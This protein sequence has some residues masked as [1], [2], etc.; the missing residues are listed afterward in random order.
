[1]KITLVGMGMGTPDT[2]TGEGLQALEQAQVIIGAQRLLE[3]LPK[4]C[5]ALC[6]QA[7]KPA[8]ILSLIEKSKNCDSLCVV[9]SGDTGFYSGSTALLPLLR[10]QG[11][12]PKVICGI[13][14]V[15]YFAAQL[16]RPWQNVRLVSAHGVECDVVGQVLMA[17][18]TFFLTGG[19][20]TIKAMLECL[21]DAGLGELEVWVG[22][23]LSLP[24]QHITH[25]TPRQLRG[26]EFASLS[27]LWVRRQPQKAVHPFQIAGIPDKEFIRG[28][29]PMTK[30]EV[31]AAILAKLCLA[32]GEV[33]W[34]VG[35]GT[36]SVSVELARVSPLTKVFAVETE[37]EALELIA[38]NRAKF[39]AFQIQ[40]VPGMAPAA[41]APLPAP[42]AVFVGGSKGNLHE[43]L[44]SVLDKNARARVVI[45]AIALETLAEAIQSCKALEMQEMEVTQISVSRTRE[46]GRYHMLTGQNPIFLISARGKETE[47]P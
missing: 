40:I 6:Y 26:R 21:E 8:E 10:E 15:Q 41:L 37:A 24:S 5:T 27:A 13:T 33:A 20:W 12:T 39:G 45:S 42:D 38:Q 7:V 32:P 18:E 22:E 29:V 16:G 31:R 1:M 19:R 11:E 23:E 30:Q 2:L 28:G 36:G 14:T 44:A 4:N 43:I 47:Q 35:A 3:A 9:M 34:D 25:G 17:E 46:V